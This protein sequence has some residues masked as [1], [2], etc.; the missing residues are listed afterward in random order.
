M[1][2]KYADNLEAAKLAIVEKY[3]AFM[4]SSYEADGS[5]WTN[6]AVKA[7]GKYLFR[8]P[9][10]EE[11]YEA[12]RKESAILDILHNRL[13][14][15][16]KVPDYQYVSLDGDYPYVGYPLIE[17]SFLRKELFDSLSGAERDKILHGMSEFLRILHAVDYRDLP[18]AEV[19]PIKK[20][21]EFYEKIEKIC[22]PYFD[23]ALKEATM[24]LF[25]GFFHDP[26]MH[27]YTPVLI[28]GDLSDDHILIAEDG[29]GIID[30]GDLMVFDP[31]YDFI[32]AYC[33]S[34]EFYDQLCRLY[35]G[36]PTADFE[37]RIRDF[38]MIRPPY[39]GILYASE[40]RNRKMLEEELHH[41]KHNLGIL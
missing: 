7:D 9:R 29:I 18:L 33:C 19:D 26:A 40:T 21:T 22:F 16:I 11:A 2:R 30:F 39:D 36:Q 20:Y 10:N 31:A 23:A 5:G 35:G 13:P 37:H 38:H 28:H 8:F 17:G 3:P 32:W 15:Y 14:G 25:D 6:Y 34:R 12:I 41:L 1:T 27:N 4:D 24:K